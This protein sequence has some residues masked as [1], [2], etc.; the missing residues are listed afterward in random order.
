MP[1]QSDRNTLDVKTFKPTNENTIGNAKFDAWKGDR[2]SISD[3]ERY[4]HNNAQLV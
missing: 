1:K 2:N 3:L 4:M